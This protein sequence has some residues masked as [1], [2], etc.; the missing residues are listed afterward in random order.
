VLAART[1][2]EALEVAATF[3]GGIDALI[4]DVVMPGMRGPELATRLR[5]LRPGLKVA[6][7]TGYADAPVAQELRAGDVLLAKPLSL[8]QL[9]SAVGR[10][11]PAAGTRRTAG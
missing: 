10:M 5:A 3:A 4:T 9:L 8:D 11:L 2:E 1:G 6:F 7:V